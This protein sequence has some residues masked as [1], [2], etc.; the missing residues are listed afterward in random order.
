MKREHKFKEFK[1][2]FFNFNLLISYAFEIR[3]INSDEWRA[4]AWNRKNWSEKKP[5]IRY[6]HTL[7]SSISFVFYFNYYYFNLE[8]TLSANIFKWSVDPIKVKTFNP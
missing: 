3:I 8:I 2:V 5:I 7:K 6:N 1:K 4:D